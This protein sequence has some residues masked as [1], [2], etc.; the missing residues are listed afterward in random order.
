M[1]NFSFGRNV[2]N[3]KALVKINIFLLDKFYQF[4]EIEKEVVKGTKC[5]FG[6]CGPGSPS[7]EN[8]TCAIN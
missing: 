7:H 1:F 8:L 5:F 4:G 3:Q 2:T 6:K